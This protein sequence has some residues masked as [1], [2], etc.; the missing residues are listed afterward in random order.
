[1]QDNKDKVE[2]NKPW[3]RVNP[4]DVV[5]QQHG[6]F[7]ANSGSMISRRLEHIDQ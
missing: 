4:V 2:P 1:M 3:L 6:K 5:Q 7:D